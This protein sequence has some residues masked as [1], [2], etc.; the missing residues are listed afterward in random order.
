MTPETIISQDWQLSTAGP[1]QVAQGLDDIAQAIILIVTTEKGSDPMRPDFGADV[2]PYVDRPRPIAAANITRAIVDAVNL[3][4]PR[5][6]LTAV[7]HTFGGQNRINFRIAWQLAGGNVDGVVE[8]A[9]GDS[10]AISSTATNPTLTTFINPTIAPTLV[11]SLNWQLALDGPGRIVQA[12]QDIGQSILLAV[13]T[14][15]GSDPLRPDFGCDLFDYIDNPL[16]VAGP[17]MARAIRESVTLWEPRVVLS[18][19]KYTLQDDHGETKRFPAGIRFQIGWRL[20]GGDLVGQTDVF[21]GFNDDYLN[22][23]LNPPVIANV[24]FILATENL[25]PILTEGDDEILIQ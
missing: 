13:S 10:L 20:H 3:W 15:K 7:D 9:F 2:L 8:V 1:G 16:A 14:M 21:L 12:V 23:L 11:K 17:N 22:N 19:V 25:D 24:F 4:E 18:G 6:V 5:V